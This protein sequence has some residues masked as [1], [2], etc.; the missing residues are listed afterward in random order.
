MEKFNTFIFE[1]F[2][3]NK[4]D[5][6]AKFYYSFDNGKEIFEEVIDFKSAFFNIPK[7]SLFL[8]GEGLIILN[9][10][11]FNLHIAL[12]ISYYKLF[13]TEILEVKSGFLD[14]EQILFWEK[15]YRNGL[16][17]FF[18][19]NY[20]DFSELI[21]F[22]NIGKVPN[23][24]ELNLINNYINADGQQGGF[25]PLQEKKLL[26]WGG[27]K[28]SIASYS[29]LNSPSIG[30]R[31]GARGGVDFDLF[32]FGKIDDIKKNTAEIAEK[33][34]LLV[35]RQL[36]NNLFKL[37]Q[38][39]YYNGHVPITGIIAFI[40]FVVSYL[41]GYSNIILSNEKSASEENTTWK[42]LKI[43]HQYSKSI[44]FESDLNK[45]LEKYLSKKINYFSLLRGMY[46]YKIAKIFSE[47]KK[48][49]NTFSS[50]NRNFKINKEGQT[51][52][53]TPTENSR[54]E[55]CIHPENNLWCCECEKCCF[56]FLMLSVN[57]DE[58][59]LV[60]IFGENLFN[61]ISLEKTFKELIG[62]ENHK[63]FECVGTYEESLL[64]AKKTIKK[65]FSG[66]ILE[67]LKQDIFNKCD[68]KTEE[69]LEKKLLKTSGEDNIPDTFSKILN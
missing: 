24:E 63:P 69:N 57:L 30:K 14:E 18:I 19:K 23:I 66:K 7:N 8:E 20:I 6:V 45:Y 34:I 31:E 52:G 15:F 36:S 9:N 12:G 37:N 26:L 1:R 25:S 65:G 28:D 29:L 46:E 60:K 58:K 56:V 49:F 47:E 16:G 4:T 33:E 39:G 22:K 27:G 61:K 53:T 68:E 13:P 32:V 2:D 11:L 55:S 40:T 43:N 38:Q 67:N 10:F 21:N 35:K 51:Q 48:F 41:Y 17:E 50:C 42:G 3:F 44:E 62:L 54:G 5:L 59:E 64:S